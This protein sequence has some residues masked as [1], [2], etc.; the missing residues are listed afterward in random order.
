[1]IAMLLKFAFELKFVARKKG[2]KGSMF[3]DL[4]GLLAMGTPGTLG[5]F[6]R[7]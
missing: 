1:M 3:I 4:F 5:V 6:V 7:V 2:G